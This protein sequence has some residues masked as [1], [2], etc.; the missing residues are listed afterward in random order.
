MAQP[1]RL[2]YGAGMTSRTADRLA[3]VATALVLAVLLAAT[4]SPPMNLEGNLPGNDK[5]HHFLGFAALTFPLCA[6]NPRAA[7]WLVPV[8]V[9]L[10]GAI[11][12]IQP[13][14]GR[15]AEWGDFVADGAGALAGAGL[16]WAIWRL[17]R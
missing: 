14:V 1:A 16:G 2:R 13:L 7:F 4:L 12:L 5:L 11:E 8:A 6:R 9:V 15:T 3:L 10:G 17:R